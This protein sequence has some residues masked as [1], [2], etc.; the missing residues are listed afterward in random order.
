MTVGEK[1]VREVEIP[2]EVEMER[3]TKRQRD[4]ERKQGETDISCK[5]FIET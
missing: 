3:N 4:G 5:N 1:K 2:R